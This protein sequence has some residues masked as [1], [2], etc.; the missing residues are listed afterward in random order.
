MV[1]LALQLNSRTL[2]SSVTLTGFS[3][4]KARQWGEGEKQQHKN[5]KIFMEKGI[6]LCTSLLINSKKVVLND[7]LR[8][9]HL[10]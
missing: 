4:R 5:T 6:T 10:P 3:E 9:N 8:V 1:Y 2:R 7:T